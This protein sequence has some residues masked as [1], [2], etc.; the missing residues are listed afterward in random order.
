MY[1]AIIRQDVNNKK[2]PFNPAC[3]N[4]PPAYEYYGS[5]ETRT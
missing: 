4:F 2:L 3:L 5:V 1:T